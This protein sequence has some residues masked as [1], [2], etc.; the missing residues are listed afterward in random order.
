MTRYEAKQ[1]LAALKKTDSYTPPLVVSYGMGLD[2][3]AMLIEMHRRGE[4]A[5]DAIVFADTGAEK[6]ETYDYLP[7]INGWLESVGWPQVTVIR[8]Q[9]TRAPYNNL[10]GKCL[11]NETLPSLAF[12]KHSCSLV[13][14]AEQQ[15]KWLKTWAP[16]KEAWA[17]GHRVTKCIGYDASPADTRRRNKADTRVDKQRTKG[18]WEACHVNYQYPIQ[19]WGYDRP[20][21]RAIIERAGLPVPGKSA[22]FFCPAA[23]LEEVLDLKLKHPALYARAVKIENVAREGRHGFKADWVQGLGLGSWAWG[24]ISEAQTLAEA[25]A[26][27]LANGGKIRQGLRP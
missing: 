26:M 13:F 2:S 17:R 18:A 15:E 3:T 6:P 4:P 23:K 19:D 20:Q 8:Y 25:T 16:A 9:P 5:P 11:S 24:W 1:R 12:G 27:I 21:L 7:T 14:K 10:E 22:C